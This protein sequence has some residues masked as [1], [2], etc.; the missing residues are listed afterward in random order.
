MATR[1]EPGS[2]AEASRPKLLQVRVLLGET[3]FEACPIDYG[4]GT[5]GKAA[6]SS[7]SVRNLARELGYQPG[8]DARYDGKA[9]DGVGAIWSI[10]E[11]SA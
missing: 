9:A 5:V 10:V 6:T 2:A 8:F 7:M 4:E 1:K 11:V 3:G